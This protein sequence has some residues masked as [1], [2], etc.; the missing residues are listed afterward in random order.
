MHFVEQR[1]NPL[2][3]VEHHPVPLGEIAEMRLQSARI[4]REL[5]RKACVEQIEAQRAG[6]HVAQPRA[7]PGCARAE[8]K[9][10]AIGALKKPRQGHDDRIQT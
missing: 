5:Q 7:L 6:Q 4:S 2:N 9:E 8:Q 1:R 3:L 10:R